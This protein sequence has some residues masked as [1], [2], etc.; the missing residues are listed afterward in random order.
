MRNYVQIV[1]AVTVLCQ[2]SLA[3]EE[4]PRI[5]GAEALPKV[6]FLWP[7][8]APGAKGDSDNDKPALTIYLPHKN[9]ATGTAVVICP[10][11]GYGGLA[12]GKEGHEVARWL[13]LAGVAGCILKY[14]HGG[15][16][17]YRHPAPLQDAQ[18]AIR[19]VRHR[20]R[21]WNIDP[22]QVGILGFSAGG[23]LAS[24][25]GTHFDAGD[26][27]AIDPIERLGCRPD[28]MILIYPVISMYEP[29]VNHGSR[30]NLLGENPD[31]RLLEYLS[32]EKQVTGQTPPTFIIHGT[33]DTTVGVENSIYFYLALRRSGVGAEMH[34]YDKVGHSFGLNRTEGPIMSWPDRCLDWMRSRD[35]LN[36]RRRR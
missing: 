3:A 10:G 21:E 8:G 32:N 6:R 11:G 28:F 24:T 17:G 36:R 25:A 23:H 27:N 19:I 33:N 26:P 29:I 34:I 30:T 18:R 22:N 9:I 35:L 14:R 12:I 31:P 7:D 5:P 2:I 20:A 15:R 16:G 13:N 4:A 1:L